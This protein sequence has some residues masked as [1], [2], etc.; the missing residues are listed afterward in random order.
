MSPQ[1]TF[2]IPTFFHPRRTCNV[3]KSIF[4]RL[5][6]VPHLYTILL[7]N[8]FST[9][10]YIHGTQSPGVFFLNFLRK[11]SRKIYTYSLNF[12][13]SK[14]NYRGTKKDPPGSI[15]ER[16]INS[17]VRRVREEVINWFT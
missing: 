17:L 2:R 5:R 15:I 14:P 3:L 9:I 8:K 6:E 11:I 16:R 13:L 10:I 12:T 1:Q 7:I 4:I